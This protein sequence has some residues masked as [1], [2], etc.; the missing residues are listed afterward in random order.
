MER[1]NKV[2]DALSHKG[3]LWKLCA[4]SFPVATSAEEL[5]ESYKSDNEIQEILR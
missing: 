5:K 3:E 1:E 4:I 2:V